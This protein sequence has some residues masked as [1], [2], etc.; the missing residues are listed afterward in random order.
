[1]NKFKLSSVNIIP[2]LVKFRFTCLIKLINPA[3]LYIFTNLI[4][5]ETE[6]CREQTQP[7]KVK[8]FLSTAVPFQQ[9]ILI[10]KQ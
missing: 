10:N 1:M 9:Q 4:F 5:C 8:Q 3:F 2:K 7:S 6:D